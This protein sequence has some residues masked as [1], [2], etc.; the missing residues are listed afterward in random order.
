[1]LF[2]HSAIL[3]IS[4]SSVMTKHVLYILIP[5]SFLSLFVPSPFSRFCLGIHT[6][7]LVNPE[8]LLLKIHLV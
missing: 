4:F 7:F 2:L 1:M 8:E 6:H 5:K 3:T